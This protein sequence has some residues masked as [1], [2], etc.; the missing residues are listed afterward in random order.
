MYTATIIVFSA[1]GDTPLT[2][3]EGPFCDKLL[4]ENI[5]VANAEQARIRTEE[6][7]HDT[8]DGHSGHYHIHGYWNPNTQ[9]AF[10]S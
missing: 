10:I 9:D 2:N 3:R 1:I 7:I 4:E 6:L 5:E 8:Q